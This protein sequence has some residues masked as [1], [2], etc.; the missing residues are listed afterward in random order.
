MPLRFRTSDSSEG[1]NDLSVAMPPAAGAPQK[2]QNSDSDFDV[3]TELPLLESVI[4]K[5][6]F[7]KLK[8]KEKKRQEVINGESSLKQ[9]RKVHH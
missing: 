6:L 1:L 5:E 7:R 9:S 3:E 8:P 2:S 4:P